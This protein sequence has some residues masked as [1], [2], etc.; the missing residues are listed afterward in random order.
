[1][2][3]KISSLRE[4]EK[5]RLDV[6]K[7]VLW[8]EDKPVNLPL[9]EI[10]MLCVLTERSGE[11][12]TKDELLEKVWADSF[13]EESNLSRHIYV[14]RKM[15]KDFGIKD[16]IIETVPRRGY[17]FAGEVREVSN[18]EIIIEKHTRTKTLIEFEKENEAEINSKKSSSLKNFLTTGYRKA[19]LAAALVSFLLGIAAFSIYRNKPSAV[20]G[21]GI[22][23]LAVLPFITIDA[24][25]E[26]T[27]KDLGLTDILITRLGGLKEITVRPATTVFNLENEDSIS[28]GKKL[29]T[30]AVLEGI[31]YRAGEK[32]RVTMRLI[33]VADGAVVW[34]GQFEKLKTDELQIQNEIALQVTNALAPN[35]SFTEKNALAKRYTENADAFELYQKGRFQWNKRNWQAMIEAERLFRNAIDK[36]P[37]FALAY[38]GLAD[39]ISMRS[40]PREAEI[41]IRKALELDP[42][43]AEAHTALGFYQTFHQWN[44][45]EAEESFKK[46]IELNPNYAT[47]HHWYAQVLT[48]QGR[49]EEAKA[50]MR[51]ALEINPLSYNFLADLGQIYYF[52]REYK[53]AE[54]YCRKALEINSEFVFVNE[55]L[56]DIYLKTGE[57]QKA[58]DAMIAAD[59]IRGDIDNEPEEITRDKSFSI[60]RDTE[61]FSKTGIKNYLTERISRSSSHPASYPVNARYYAFLGEK[62]KT[63]D[64][65]EKAFDGR[66]F[67]TAFVKADPM[68]DDYREEPRYKEILRKMNLQ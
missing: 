19:I 12:V 49:Y 48:I 34:S 3:N 38:I 24:G 58:F 62:E 17:R 25:N 14:L 39:T 6:E 8:Y 66:A 23:S 56:T 42:N 60:K 43:L 40:E 28:A 46:A 29:Q 2:N 50:E 53:E 5:F 26:N 65:L 22:K 31:V 55:Y 33:K 35:L 41:A 20:S 63:L 59:K 47:A 54:N 45:R 4:F 37:N 16:R 52:N 68:F 61:N 32:I 51:R 10:E 27:S 11:V 21:T 9:K 57:Y 1:M 30:D 15:F 18:G 13:V 67:L 36:D 44:W 64:S 7:R